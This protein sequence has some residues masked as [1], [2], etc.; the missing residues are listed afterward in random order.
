MFDDSDCSITFCMLAYEGG[1]LQN[2]CRVPMLQTVGPSWGAGGVR[3]KIGTQ[4]NLGSYVVG[5]F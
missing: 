1:G 4:D 2:G 3:G 5:Q